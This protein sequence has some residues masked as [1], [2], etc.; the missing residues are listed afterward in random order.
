MKNSWGK[1]WGQVINEN[2]DNDD[3]DDDDDDDELEE[4][5][6]DQKV[7]E[8]IVGARKISRPWFYFIFVYFQ[9]G[10]IYLEYG[11]N[12]CGMAKSPLYA[13]VWERGRNKEKTLYIML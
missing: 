3:D 12:V 7:G 9:G 4:G 1:T 5:E 13:E 8:G 11:K 2:Y 10:Y 6:F